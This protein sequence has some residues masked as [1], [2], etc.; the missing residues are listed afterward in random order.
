MGF[1][2]IAMIKKKDV[3]EMKLELRES[4]WKNIFEVIRDKET[5]LNAKGNFWAAIQRLEQQCEDNGL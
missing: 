1:V 2:M 4:S 3:N 5:T